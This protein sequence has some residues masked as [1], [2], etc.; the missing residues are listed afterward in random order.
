MAI[1][2]ND[3]DS[4]QPFEFGRTLS[5]VLSRDLY[6]NPNV[7]IREILSNIYDQY[8]HKDARDSP[9]F[10]KAFIEV[11][12]LHHTLR[13]IDYA[14]GIEDVIL[15][16]LIGSNIAGKT[17]GDK[18]STVQ[19]PD[20]DIIG[21][22][23]VGK[24]S[25]P[26]L[27]KSD[28]GIV[29][30][31]ESISKNEGIRLAMIKRPIEGGDFEIGWDKTYASKFPA[32]LAHLARKEKQIGL[33]VQI[34][35]V[36][37]EFLNVRHIKAIVAK[38]FG[39]L[40][41]LKGFKIYIRDTATSDSDE[42]VQIHPP[43]DLNTDGIETT[44]VLPNGSHPFSHRLMPCEKPRFENIDLYVKW[45]WIT[46]FRHPG[47]KVTGLVNDN[48]IH[49]VANR[50]KPKIDDTYDAFKAKFTELVAKRFDKEGED[51]RSRRLKSTKELLHRF[52]NM[53]NVVQ[54]LYQ[55]EPLVL[56]G[57]SNDLSQIKG[58]IER[59]PNQVEAWVKE[60][61]KK[62]TKE[63]GKPEEGPI[64][65]IGPH[66]KRK[67]GKRKRRS[68]TDGNMPSAE[69]GGEHDI[70]RGVTTGERPET[71]PIEPSL[72]I[73]SKDIGTERPL[74]YME[75]ANLLYLNTDQPAM[76]TIL[77]LPKKE[78]DAALSPFMAEAL[79]EFVT[80][81][82]DKPTSI[83]EYR[84]MINDIYTRSFTE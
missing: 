15:F 38:Q 44:Q 47:R 20:E 36:L 64:I 77:Q 75:R 76:L 39:L 6:S 69:E 19:N 70:L 22:F 71:G 60:T 4:F 41:K 40:I 72:N 26:S 9:Y 78:K 54:E 81:L 56:S 74:T 35:N 84:Q 53:L 37:D 29:V 55:K 66:K 58:Q 32:D 61:K 79:A 82:R 46:S 57:I 59:D 65:P 8:L 50:E 13:V 14:T 18:R 73:I 42:F 51:K 2:N 12:S 80:R 21:Q 28:T 52:K 5:I 45:I 31:F 11:D 49:L 16:K 24:A 33:S 25:F 3:D 62:L 1:N 7:G 68:G 83:E 17:V 43:A 34:E 23:H 27:S 10:M 67:K 30:K 48:K 63:G